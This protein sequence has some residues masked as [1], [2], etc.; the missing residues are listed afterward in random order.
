[1]AIARIIIDFDDTLFDTIYLKADWAKLLGRY[2]IDNHLFQQTYQGAYQDESGRAAFS[3]ER[4]LSILE[5]TVLNL[6][7][8]KIQKNKEK[9]IKGL[10]GYLKEGAVDFL[11]ALKRKGFLLILLSLGAQDYQRLKIKRTGIGKYFDKIITVDESKARVLRSLLGQKFEST[12]LIN[13]K[14]KESQ[15]IAASFPK[16]KII[17]MVSPVF[18]LKDY[19]TSGLP[20]F[21]TFKQILNYLNKI[22]A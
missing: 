21:K 20:Y 12:I 11:L 2:G 7:K 10:G 16:L 6:D 22:S 9:F 1:M 4:H 14:I 3:F 19:Q 13:D 18:S 8:V 5:K 15:E 17:L